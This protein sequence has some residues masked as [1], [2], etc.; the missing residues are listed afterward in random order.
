MCARRRET[1]R[2]CCPLYPALVYVQGGK[3]ASVVTCA[4]CMHLQVLQRLCACM[5]MCLVC[6]GVWP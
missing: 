2:A 1:K 3:R 5:A 4:E 6:Q